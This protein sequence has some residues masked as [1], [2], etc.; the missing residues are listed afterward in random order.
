MISS[1]VNL[2]IVLVNFSVLIKNAVHVITQKQSN[3]ID[4]ILWSDAI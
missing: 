1:N 4:R 3:Y 2:F